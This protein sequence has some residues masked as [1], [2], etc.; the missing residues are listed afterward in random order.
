MTPFTLRL[1]GRKNAGIL[2]D[3][4]P[5]YAIFFPV[6]LLIAANRHRN[7][8]PPARITVPE[9]LDDAETQLLGFIGVGDQ[10]AWESNERWD[11]HPP[12]SLPPDRTFHKT[13]PQKLPDWYLE[14]TPGAWVRHDAENVILHINEEE[15]GGWK[16]MKK[17]FENLFGTP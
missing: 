13:S 8:E 16:R 10:L 3:G 5:V 4:I 6:P 14:E 1:H 17:W 2:I 9:D 11:D 12:R 15:Q 7:E